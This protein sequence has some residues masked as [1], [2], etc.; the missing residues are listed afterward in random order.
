MTAVSPSEGYNQHSTYQVQHQQQMEPPTDA[1]SQWTAP[2]PSRYSLQSSGAAQSHHHLRHSESASSLYAASVGS[3][4]D[5]EF[6]MPLS[7]PA[8]KQI[9]D[10]NS[11]Y[12]PN[13]GLSS[14][15]GSSSSLNGG[16]GPIRRHRS[17][18]PSFHKTDEGGLRR[19]IASS[20]PQFG[21][22]VAR[23]YHPYA[24]S[25][26][27]SSS[28]HSSPASYPVALANDYNITG[29]NGTVSRSSSISH[30]S[31][32]QRGSGVSLQLQDQMH[33]MLNLDHM[34]EPLYAHAN[35][36]ASVGS[37]R[38][39]SPA[40]FGAPTHSYMPDDGFSTNVGNGA[41][42]PTFFSQHL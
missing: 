42:D 26:Y 1:Y 5:N 15:A 37:Y 9:F 32:S 34:E 2:G 28:V 36:N 27:S 31:R 20:H 41:V 38:T 22:G 25:S 23:G 24:P 3:L 8:H 7:A 40:S 13:V 29:N 17:M 39:D 18:T 10:H 33:Q 21:G 30:H 11:L 14:S 19:P 35:A 12:P 16:L 4:S 6:A